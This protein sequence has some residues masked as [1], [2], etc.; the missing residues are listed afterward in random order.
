MVDDGSDESVGEILGG[1]GVSEKKIIGK[2]LEPSARSR[3]G[4]SAT[5]EKS[6][7][8]N[9][10]SKPSFNQKSGSKSKYEG[11]HNGTASLEYLEDLDDSQQVPSSFKPGD[12]DINRGPI[13]DSAEEPLPKK[14]KTI[15]KNPVAMSGESF[16]TKNPL[17][18]SSGGAKAIK[19][20][21]KIEEDFLENE[22]DDYSND[23]EN[24]F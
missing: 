7:G 10:L 2:P 9:T 13:R 5:A 21:K 22:E 20:S 15:G 8:S 23:F 24:Q 11:G 4:P 19:K 12:I 16:G 3:Y 14:K 1:M 17:V 6:K 18:G